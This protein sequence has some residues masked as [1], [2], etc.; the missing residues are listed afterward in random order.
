MNSQYLP[1]GDT[2]SLNMNPTHSAFVSM[3]FFLCICFAGPLTGAHCNPAI[4]LALFL[5][6]NS[7]LTLKTATLYVFSQFLGAMAGGAIAYGLVPYFNFDEEAPS[8]SNIRVLL[9]LRIALAQIAGTFIYTLFVLIN[10]YENTSF[11]KATF[12]VYVSTAFVF[13]ISREFTYQLDSLNPATTLAFQVFTGIKNG[14]WEPLKQYYLYI[15]GPVIGAILCSAFYN[16]YYEPLLLR[17][18]SP[19]K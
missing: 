13:F 19:K 10:Y 5:T 16:F 3:V 18:R 17:W 9:E 2:S 15:A 7:K 14:N 6:P 11:F 4:T 12:W 8:D 1:S